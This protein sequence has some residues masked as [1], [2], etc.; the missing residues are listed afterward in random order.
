[1]FHRR[2][3]FIYAYSGMMTV[4][5]DGGAWAVPPQRALWMPPGIAH[6]IKVSGELKMRT[7]YFEPDTAIERAFPRSCAVIEVTMLMRE[8]ILRAVEL[9]S[10]NEAG[11]TRFQ[12]LLKVLLDEIGNPA[13]L[14]FH[15]PLPADP[16]IAKICR[17]LMADPAVNFT[18]PM[19]G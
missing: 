12:N 11:G 4:I 14:S 16:R 1:H 3:Q 2:A 6:E 13:V 5:T 15:L 7:L 19:W 10:E 9:E 18:L 17:A 8:L